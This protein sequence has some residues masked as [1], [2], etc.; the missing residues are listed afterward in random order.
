MW[1]RDPDLA[2]QSLPGIPVYLREGTVRLLWG[3]WW[4]SE[5]LQLSGAR[6]APSPPDLKEEEEE[7]YLRAREGGSPGQLARQ[8]RL[9]TASS[10]AEADSSPSPRPGSA[11]SLCCLGF[12]SSQHRH[13]HVAT[14]PSDVRLSHH[15]SR[16]SEPT[17]GL[18]WCT[19]VTQL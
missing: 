15:P 18:W 6:A 12:G 5:L 19:P 17:A 10:Q 9:L 11:G 1:A 14:S 13:T 16:V 2:N 7:A 4:D 3:Y 8:A